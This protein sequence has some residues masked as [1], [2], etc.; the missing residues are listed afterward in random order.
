MQKTLNLVNAPA[1]RRLA[2]AAPRAD[3][4]FRLGSLGR[5]QDI[6]PAA[7]DEE[8]VIAKHAGQLRNHRMI[9]GKL[10]VVLDA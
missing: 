3:G 9:L 10:R 4:R 6:E 7:V 2:V 8:R 5:F 1:G